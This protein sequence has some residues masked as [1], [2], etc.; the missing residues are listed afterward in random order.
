V[1]NRLRLRSIIGCGEFAIRTEPGNLRLRRCSAFRRIDSAFEPSL[2]QRQSP[3]SGNAIFQGRD[4]DPETAPAI[5]WADC[6][7]KMRARIAASSGLFALNRE[8]SVCAG[9]RGGAERTQTSNQAVM[10]ALPYPEKSVIIGNFRT[11][12]LTSVRVWLRHIIGYLLVGYENLFVG[13][14]GLLHEQWAI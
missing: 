4:K 6:R 9:L 13:L 2:Y 12:S 8:I 3:P 1:E 10:S 11:G 14:R 7:D 5:Q